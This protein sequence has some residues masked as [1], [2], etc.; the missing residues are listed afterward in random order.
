MSTQDDGGPAFPQSGT[1][2][3]DGETNLGDNARLIAAAPELLECCLNALGAYE[4]LRLI[5]ADRGLLGFHRLETLLKAA[6]AKAE[7]A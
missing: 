7:G 3:D 1:T 2:W 6:I 5:G 4:A